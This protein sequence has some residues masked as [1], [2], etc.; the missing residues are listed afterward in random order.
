[1]KNGLATCLNENDISAYQ[2]DLWDKIDKSKF[3]CN[4]LY[5]VRGLAFNVI[6]FEDLKTQRKLK[7]DNNFAKTLQS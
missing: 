2:E 7:S 1:M 4:G 5:A 6:N 3:C